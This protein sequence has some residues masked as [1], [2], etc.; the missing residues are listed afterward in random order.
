MARKALLITLALILALAVPALAQKKTGDKS[1]TPLSSSPSVAAKGHGEVT[2]FGQRWSAMSDKERE[3]F[4]EG[5][6][7]AFRIMC[8]NVAFS[9]V[10]SSK[11]NPQD[12]QKSFMDC[13]LAQFPYKPGVVKEAMT[14]LYLDKAN[15]IIPYDLMFGMALLKV[16]GDPFEDNL[17]KLRQDLTRRGK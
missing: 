16:K 6:A 15:N 1:A 12:V 9:G 7:T 5:I 17:V 2:N 11:A 13:F 14:S 10:D 3:F 4:L 8:L